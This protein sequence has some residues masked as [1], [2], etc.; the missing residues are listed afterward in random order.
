MELVR[1]LSVER[2]YKFVG[3]APLA[4]VLKVYMQFF[5]PR[6]VF[7]GPSPRQDRLL[8]YIS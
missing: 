6:A 1:R 2:T 8:Y 5:Y 3:K 4:C 7:A